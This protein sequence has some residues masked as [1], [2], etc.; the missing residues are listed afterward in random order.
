MWVFLVTEIMFFGGLFLAYAVARF[1]HPEAFAEA[2]H[3]L[4]VA[5]G[6]INTAVL[7]ASSLTMAL[8]VHAAQVGQ[9]RALMGFLTLTAALGCVFL[10]IK[11]IE[12]ADKFQHHLVPGSA[13]SFAG[14]EARPA[15]LFF[16][17]YF[18]MTGLHALH[19]VIGVG[20][21]V[22]LLV[23]AWKGRYSVQY[24]IPIEVAGLYWHFVDIIWIFLFPLL[25][26]IDIHH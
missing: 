17:L 20:V 3:H 11:G 22:V 21:V 2:S 1:L 5:L 6:G 24:H 7:I 9:R 4:N 23:R 10:L 15:E 13:F 25:Y 18:A 16:S 12:Y 19:M 8:A 26:L 14:P